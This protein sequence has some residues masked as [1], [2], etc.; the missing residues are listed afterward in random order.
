MMARLAAL[1]GLGLAVTLAAPSSGWG[2]ETLDQTETPPVSA[3]PKYSLWGAAK[4]SLFGDVY[5]HPER[6]QPM[7]LG[8]FF[9][10]GWNEPW[11]SPPKGGG[12]AP[13]QS[14]LN[15]FNG[16]FYR[17][18]ST[19]GGWAHGDGGDAY[20]GSLTVD[21]P[22]NAR[23]QLQ[24]TVPYVAS[25]LGADGDR[26][27]GFGDFSLTTRFLLSETQDVTQSFNVAFRAP[28]GDVANHNAVAS[29]TPD[30]EFWAN[31]W[32]G[33][34]VRGG[35]GLAVPFNHDGL[36]KAGARTTFL[37]NLAA[38]YYFT[39]H[40]LAPVGDLVWYVSTNLSQPTDNRA[41]NNITTLTFTPGFRTYLGWNL[42]L[43]GG[44]EV[45]A[46][47]PK[48]FDYQVLGEL[49]MPF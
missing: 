48:A 23:T 15:A 1:L 8:T 46:T 26:H 32:R 5:A 27:T 44:V 22:L 38:G 2:E 11:V 13:R 42:Y 17:L 10:E 18:V 9:T 40:D 24:W 34:V 7:S 16:V 43:F 25:N 33:L 41:P 28:T 19:T 4:E 45:P 30:Y 12:G 49:L 39:P 31:W 35:V 14:W 37:A 3:R 47:A 21:T 6:W 29:I 36:T 20:S